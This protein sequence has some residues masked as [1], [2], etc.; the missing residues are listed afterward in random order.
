MSELQ[1]RTKR[2]RS[3]DIKQ[4]VLRVGESISEF[5]DTLPAVTFDDSPTKQQELGA[6]LEERRLFR[7]SLQ[8]ML[9]AANQKRSSVKP[10]NIAT[11]RSRS[12]LTSYNSCDAI[13]AGGEDDSDNT[14]RNGSSKNEIDNSGNNDS[15]NG[16]MGSTTKEGG[17]SKKTRAT[18]DMLDDNDENRLDGKRVINEIKLRH[19]EQEEDCNNEEK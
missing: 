1:A 19:K 11:R 15:S 18:I 6:E 13:R 4:L 9:R 3:Q 17:A 2:K 16:S 12:P 14:K 7:M 10:T 5:L 8:R